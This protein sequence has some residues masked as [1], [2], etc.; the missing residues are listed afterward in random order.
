MKGSDKKTPDAFLTAVFNLSLAKPHPVT[1]AALPNGD[2]AL[3]YLRAIKNS[4]FNKLSTEQQQQFQKKIQKMF[5]D[6]IYQFYMLSVQKN[7]NTKIHS[8]K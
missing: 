5:A 1:T 4:D 8:V 7:I 6:M 3:I 2:T